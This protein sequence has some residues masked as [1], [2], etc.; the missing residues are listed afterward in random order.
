MLKIQQF[1][2]STDNFAYVIF[3]DASAGVVDGGAV[4]KILA[5]LTD[6]GLTLRFVTNTHGH[7]DHTVGTGR[8]KDLTGA[9]VIDNRTLRQ[10][11]ELELEGHKITVLDT[12]GHT[13]D[14][15]CFY[16]GNTLISGDTLFNGT[17]GNCFSGDLNGFFRSIKRLMAL[18][19][20]TVVYAGHDYLRDAMAFARSLEPQNRA[21]DLFL[22]RYDPGHVFSTLQEELQVN[23]YLK[24]NDSNIIAVLEK[25]GLPVDTE[26]RR[27]E[28]LMSLE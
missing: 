7:A 6:N 22:K 12:P 17:I 24:F 25:K 23:P 1:R 4:E 16:F 3:G 11:S 18:P 21:I 14:S 10:R 26:Y 27:W 5:F 19:A 28:S 9:V 15:L 20:D 8:L 13:A 2:Y